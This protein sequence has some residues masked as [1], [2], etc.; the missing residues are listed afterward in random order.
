MNINYFPLIF[1]F[2]DFVFVDH[3][4]HIFYKCFQLRKFMLL[5]VRKAY[6]YLMQGIIF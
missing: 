1:L 6:K 3:L 4:V 5:L 2:V